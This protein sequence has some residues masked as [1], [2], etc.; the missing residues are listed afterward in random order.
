MISITPEILLEE[1]EILNIG[2]AEFINDSG[3]TY[4]LL[5]VLL[6]KPVLSIICKSD[7]DYENLDKLFSG[8]IRRN[9]IKPVEDGGRYIGDRDIGNYPS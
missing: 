4:K 8:I 2:D 9:L 6:D 7:T 3:V 5:M 1:S